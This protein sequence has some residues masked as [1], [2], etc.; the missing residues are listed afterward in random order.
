MCSGL[1]IL[2][3]KILRPELRDALCFMRRYAPLK[4][5]PC[6]S[7]AAIV[8]FTA[9]TPLQCWLES[10]RVR[11]H[12]RLHY[13]SRHRFARLERKWCNT[14]CASLCSFKSFAL[15]FPRPRPG[16]IGSQ[17]NKKRHTFR[18]VLLINQRLPI[19][20]G[21]FQPSTFGVYELNYCVRDGNRWILVAIA[22]E[23]VRACTLKTT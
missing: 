16:R 17:Y 14:I 1:W 21:R 2:Q 9:C 20:P 15:L 11:Y 8:P 7:H 12:L 3:S 23:F 4:H 18:C 10:L 19:L 5:E 22:T 6:V 13:H